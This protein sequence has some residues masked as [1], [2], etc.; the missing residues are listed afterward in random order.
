VENS[1]TFEKVEKVQLMKKLPAYVL[2]LILLL[3]LTACGASQPTVQHHFNWKVQNFSYTDQ[4]NKPFG[5]SDLKGKVWIADFIYTNCQTICPPMTAH[6]ASIQKELRKAGLSAE[7]VSFS[8]DPGN[9][10]PKKLVDFGQKFHVDFSNWHFLTGYSDEQIKQLSQGSF[11]SALIKD[12][13]NDIMHGTSFFLVDQ[14]GTVI[15]KYSGTNSKTDDQIIKDI[16]AI[17]KET[18]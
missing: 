8:I 9:D 11:K 5:L 3:G 17:E 1:N 2:S 13:P 6:M 4:N 7:I 10:T 16:T 12:S 15:E 14:S 18:K